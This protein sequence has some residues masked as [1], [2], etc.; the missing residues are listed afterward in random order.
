[1]ANRKTCKGCCTHEENICSVDPSIKRQGI[2][3]MCPCLNC[4]IKMVC[5]SECDSFASYE[6]SNTW[7]K[8]HLARGK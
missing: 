4:I 5:I 1:M 8:W 2:K 6:T 3:L 7:S